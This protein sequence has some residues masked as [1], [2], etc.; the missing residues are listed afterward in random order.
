M[1]K[2]LHDIEQSFNDEHLSRKEKAELK[3]IIAEEQP[4]K[5][6][7]DW[8]RSKIFDLAQ[9][10]F[11]E[12]EN[13]QVLHWLEETNKLLLQKAHKEVENKVYFSPGDECL[14]A[15]CN[16]ISF[17]SSSIDVCVFTISDNRIKDK[18]LYAFGKG[19][20]V[21][22][23]TDND[24]SFDRGSD[25]QSLHEAGVSIKMDS[26]RHH[27]H[28]KFA[29]FDKKLAL[30]GS[31]NWTRSASAYNHENILI[32]DH[33]GAVNSYRKEFDRLWENLNPY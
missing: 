2:I 19:V 33:L 23:I 30:T 26:S 18:L 7:L 20:R 8:L 32:T 12:N 31:F 4:D 13:Q 6:E 3:R 14:R 10:K 27:M 9:S 25:I 22:I 16:Q 11:S 5:Q 24:K 17:A 29:V 28:H 21:R 1:N 15:V